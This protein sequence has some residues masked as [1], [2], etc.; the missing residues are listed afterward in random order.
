MVKVT[1][2]PLPQSVFDDSSEEEDEDE[3]ALNEML[4]AEMADQYQ[5]GQIMDMEDDDEDD[6]D[7]EEVDDEIPEDDGDEEEEEEDED[8]EDEEEEDDEGEEDIAVS[9]A[10]P[11]GIAKINGH[12]MDLDGGDGDDDDD[13]EDDEEDDDYEDDRV[14]E[15]N[16]LCSL[17]AGK[18]KCTTDSVRCADVKI[19]QANLNITFT[20]G[21][22]V[23]FEVTGKKCVTCMAIWCSLCQS[24]SSPWELRD[25]EPPPA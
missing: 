23:M 6:D 5:A 20:E 18:V 12:A 7:D 13:E 4:A 10:K 15:T 1:H 16:V 24:R 17:T 9:K 14:E 19:E 2:H 25:A 11:N 22:V 3:E 8:A 21:D